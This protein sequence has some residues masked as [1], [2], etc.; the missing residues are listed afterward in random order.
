MN[1]LRVLSRAILQPEPRKYTRR[2]TFVRKSCVIE[3]ELRE[4]TLH[5]EIALSLVLE[6]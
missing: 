4:C 1:A 6:G 5:F 2:A 3:P